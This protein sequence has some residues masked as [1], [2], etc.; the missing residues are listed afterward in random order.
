MHRDVAA[1]DRRRWVSFNSG[2]CNNSN[3]NYNCNCNCQCNCNWLAYLLL[4]ELM[5]RQTRERR[6]TDR[7]PDCVFVYVPM[8]ALFQFQLH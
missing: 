7:Q 5:A 2:R 1:V 4:G 8:A 3:C 6:R